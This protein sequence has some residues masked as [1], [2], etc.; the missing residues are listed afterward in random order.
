MG[1][2]G[3][4]SESAGVRTLLVVQY[5]PNE[6]RAGFNAVAAPV[7]Q[8]ARD[9]GIE[10]IDFFKALRELLRH[11]AAAFEALYRGHMSP[12]GNRFVAG[13][14]WQRLAR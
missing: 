5:T 3:R 13:Q 8:C 12:A 1:R 4:L 6:A 11:G 2:L 14:I 10:V 9:Q 7:V